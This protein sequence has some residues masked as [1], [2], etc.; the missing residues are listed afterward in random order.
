MTYCP[1]CD[2]QGVINKATIKGT[3]VVLYICDECDT[4]WKDM[5]ITEDNCENF[6]SVMDN[7]G[8]KALW[9]ELTDIERL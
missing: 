6:E 7:L 5:N 9:A 2:G 3:E 8:R 1:F 4:V